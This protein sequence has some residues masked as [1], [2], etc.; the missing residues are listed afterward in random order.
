MA[1]Y[2]GVFQKTFLIKRYSIMIKR[3]TSGLMYISVFL[4][5]L[6]VYYKYIVTFFAYRGYIWDFNVYKCILSL[7]LI[8]LISFFLPYKIRK[9]SD[10]LIHIH[11][12]FPF[13]FMFVL[14]TAENFSNYFIS[15]SILCFLLLIKVRNLKI[16]AVYF[17]NLRWKNINKIVILFI[18]VLFVMLVYFYHNYFNLDFSKVYDLR[19]ELREVSKGIKAYV[20]FSVLFILL[21]ILFSY[22]LVYK[23][24]L[25][26][27]LGI[28]LYIFFFAFTSHKKFFFMPFFAIYIYG[29]LKRNKL[30]FYMQI[31]IIF[32]TLFAIIIDYLWLEIWLKSLL[33]Q[34]FMFVPAQLNFFYYEF[35]SQHKFVFWTDSK[36]FL[37]GRI[38]GYPYDSPFQMIIGDYY[39]NN[40]ECIANTNWIGSGYAH[41]GV[42]GMLLYAIIVGLI[43]RFLDFKSTKFGKDFIIISFVPFITSIFLSSDLKTVFLTHG[44]LVYILFLSCIRCL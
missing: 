6:F 4:F 13:L 3:L 36:W 24:Y 26:I 35:F 18:L 29:L 23:K 14:Y 1:Q 7:S 5:M 27:F 19:L 25:F 8:F 39:F 44:L 43:L 16:P 33:I 15:I 32:L 11:F 40:P 2:L 31:G 34:R 12:M 38:F 37:L 9:P 22:S 21:H 30:I 41:A 20:F 42:T 17:F 10:F 28:V